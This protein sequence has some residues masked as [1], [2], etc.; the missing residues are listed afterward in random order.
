MENLRDFI[1]ETFKMDIDTEGNKYIYQAVDKLDK[2]H[3][4]DDECSSEAQ[5][6][7]TSKKWHNYI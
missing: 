5:V 4:D 2:N 6:K 1:K 7:G 3:Q